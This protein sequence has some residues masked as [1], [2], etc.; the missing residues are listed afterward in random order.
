MEPLKVR[1]NRKRT[2]RVNMKLNAF[3]ITSVLVKPAGVESVAM[4]ARSRKDDTVEAALSQPIDDARGSE[5]NELRGVERITLVDDGL[6]RV[7]GAI[8]IADEALC[9]RDPAPRV[10]HETRRS[11]S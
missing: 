7:D 2:I 8:A 6:V 11:E 3:K 5:G 10:V 9:L 4:L 1:R